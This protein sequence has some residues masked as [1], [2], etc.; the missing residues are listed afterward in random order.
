MYQEPAHW[1]EWARTRRV[2]RW[3]CGRTLR[4]DLL[5]GL[6]AAEM[7]TV[8]LRALEAQPFAANTHRPDCV[9]L[10]RASLNPFAHTLPPSTDR[11]AFNGRLR[12]HVRSRPREIRQRPGC[13]PTPR[14]C[15]RLPRSTFV[16]AHNAPRFSARPCICWL[17]AQRA[18]RCMSMLERDGR[19][20]R[21]ST[22][23]GRAVPE[24]PRRGVIGVDAARGRQSA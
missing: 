8:S 22:G 4:W 9:P 10:P 13:A 23:D 14:A 17:G 7:Q 3:L 5:L 19:V 20:A 18:Q 21:G 15:G 2:L 6:R 24:G 12:S 11:D 16:G 1:A